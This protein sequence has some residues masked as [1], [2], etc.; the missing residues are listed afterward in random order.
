L[1]LAG[2]VLEDSEFNGYEGPD[3]PELVIITSG[4]G[5]LFSREAV[6]TLGLESSVGVLKM[7]VTWPL[8]VRL[9]KDTMARTS[10]VLFIEEVDPVLEDNIKAFYADQNQELPRIEFMGKK[11][12]Q[13]P[14]T[15]ELSPGLI[16]EAL[17]KIMSKEPPAVPE[18]YA[19][20]A[21]DALRNYSPHR[22]LAFCAGCPHRASFWALKIALALDQ[23]D[24]VVFGDIGCY[25]LGFLPTGFQQAKTLHAMGSGAGMASGFGKLGE[26]GASQP[27]IALCGDSTFYHS[28][29]PALI[30][31]KH[32][33]SE[34]LIIILD[35]SATAMTGFQPHPGIGLDAMGGYAPPIAIENLTRA[36]GVKTVI[37]DPFDLAGTSQIILDLLSQPGTKALILRQTCALVR[38]RKESKRPRTYVDPNRCRGDDCGCNRICARVFRC[39]GLNWN[40]ETGKSEIDEA[41]CSGCGVCVDICPSN[42][43]IR[44][45]PDVA[46]E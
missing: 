3:S 28:A 18:D 26:F 25:A 31:A 7:G 21:Q 2:Q 39:P 17:G 23:R 13:I 44:E 46:G 45:I 29:I 14:D 1:Q 41:V 32:H 8:P 20:E 22:S 40:P 15:G 11:S 19:L 27:A 6:E 36:L 42:A 30:N 38:A 34:I 37:A 12:G 10:K 24:G 4:S 33:E 9:L 16:M 5:V 43:I 35:N